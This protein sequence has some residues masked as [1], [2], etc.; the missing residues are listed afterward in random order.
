MATDTKLLRAP[1]MNG[2]ALSTVP[3]R[4]HVGDVLDPE[5]KE[6]VSLSFTGRVLA[7]MTAGTDAT[8]AERVSIEVG[9]ALKP[10]VARMFDEG[11][12]SV[13]KLRADTTELRRRVLADVQRQSTTSGVVVIGIDRMN[14]ELADEDRGP[15]QKHDAELDAHGA[16][17]PAT[18]TPA[19]SATAANPDAHVGA[20]DPA[21]APAAESAA[22]DPAGLCVGQ[23]V[24]AQWTNGSFYV[25][26]ILKAQGGLYEVE[27]HDGSAPVW[28]RRDQIRA[29]P[30]ASAADGP[31]VSAP[32]S[33]G[34]YYRARVIT[35]R[36]GLCEVAWE[37]GS[38]P[39]WVRRDQIRGDIPPAATSTPDGNR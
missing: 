39:S 27:W 1:M 26:R 25:A 7:R 37:D 35:E 34:Q 16:S 29:T 12:T 3:I 24:Q 6:M 10:L 31:L 33:N 30:I 22:V 9:L 20:S 32:W 18:A 2:P 36:D 17:D 5:R 28:L 23:R 19:E 38:A 14:L 13:R 11:A 15:F 4:V 8:F 21:A